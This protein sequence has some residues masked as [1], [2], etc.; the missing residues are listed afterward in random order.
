MNNDKNDTTGLRMT[1]VKDFKC[2]DNCWNEPKR[3]DLVK[4]ETVIYG[5]GGSRSGN[6]SFKQTS[7]GRGLFINHTVAVESRHP[8]CRGLINTE[9]LEPIDWPEELLETVTE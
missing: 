5:G 2:V 9:Y 7:T 6:V 8:Y 4:G 3:V 1:V